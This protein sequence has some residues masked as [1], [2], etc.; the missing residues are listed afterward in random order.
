MKCLRF[1]GLL[2][3]NLRHQPQKQKTGEPASFTAYGPATKVPICA[4]EE[5]DSSPSVLT[6][7]HRPLGVPC[8]LSHRLL[9]WGQRKTPGAALSKP[10]CRVQNTKILLGL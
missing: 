2:I 5:R 4:G 3:R 1:Q 10:L 8:P 9:R 7:P 6:S